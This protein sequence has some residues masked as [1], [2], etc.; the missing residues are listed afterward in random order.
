MGQNLKASEAEG[1]QLWP[2]IQEHL[3]SL[4]SG[5]S[6]ITGHQPVCTSVS[7]SVMYGYWDQLALSCPRMAVG[8]PGEDG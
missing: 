4:S 2:R 5:P 8:H 6:G 3:E 7:L 1:E